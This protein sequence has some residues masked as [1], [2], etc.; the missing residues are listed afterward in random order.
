MSNGEIINS[1][2]VKTNIG[3]VIGIHR[4]SVEIKCY[5]L[6]EV[7]RYYYFLAIISSPQNQRFSIICLFIVYFFFAR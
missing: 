4:M 1:D 3:E 2:R 6:V 5:E 7:E